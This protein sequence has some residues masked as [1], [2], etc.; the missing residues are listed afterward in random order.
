MLRSA[1]VA[2]VVLALGTQVGCSE[3]C[4]QDYFDWNVA[5]AVDDL[6]EAEGAIVCIDSACE[7]ISRRDGGTRNDTARF[8]GWIELPSDEAAIEASITDVNGASLAS[9]SQRLTPAGDACYRSITLDADAD[10]IRWSED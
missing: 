9:F 4:E 3:D 8:E 5:I 6:P 2:A 7:Q 1:S 10:G